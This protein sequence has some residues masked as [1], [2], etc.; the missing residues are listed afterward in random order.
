MNKVTENENKH[1][2][3]F[4]LYY[5]GKTDFKSVSKN[6]N[7]PFCVCPTCA[8]TAFVSLRETEMFEKP[9]FTN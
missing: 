8:G 4:S 3:A 1:L 6:E 9:V 5:C 7:C 2:T